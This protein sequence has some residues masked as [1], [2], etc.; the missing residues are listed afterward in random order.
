MGEVYRARDTRLDRQVAVKVLASHLSSNPEVRTRFDREARAISKL[1]HPHICAL[2]DV[3][4]QDGIDYLV[5]EYLE[6]E[7]LADRLAKGP[8]PLNQVIRLGSEIAEALDKAHRQGIVHRDLKPGNI[9]ITDAGAKV[10][11]FGLAKYTA[12]DAA[13]GTEASALDTERKPVT[14]EGTIL[15]TIQ[16]MAPEQLEGKEAD[17]RTDI[18]ALGTILYEMATGQRAFQGHSKASLIASIMSSEPTPIGAIQPMTPPPLDR[19]VRTCLEKDPAQR[20]QSAHDIACQL[21][22]VAEAPGEPLEAISQRRSRAIIT[23]G[24]FGIAVV[25]A[26]GLAFL[27]GKTR[28]ISVPM[29]QAAILP[30]QNSTFHFDIGPLALSPDGSQLAFVATGAEGRDFVWVRPIKDVSAH[31]LS[32]TEGASFPFWSPDGRSIGFFAEGKLKTIDASGGPALT[33]CEAPESRG[34]TWGRK[35]VIL[36]AP[37]P[38][39]PIHRISSSGGKAV[40]V[41]KIDVSE[42]ELGHRWPVFLPDGKHFLYLSWTG[43]W[44]LHEEQA[45]YVGAVDSSK[46]KLL[47]RAA[48]NAAYAP[49]GYILFLRGTDLM[50]QSFNLKRQ[51]LSGEA[52]LIAEQVQYFSDRGLVV[53][54]VSGNGLLAYQAGSSTAKTQLVWLDR[55]G[56]QI[57]VLTSQGSYFSP[58]ISHDGQRV[59]VESRDAQQNPDVWIH[60]LSRR[61]GAR[62]TFNPGLESSPVWSPDDRRIVFA[63]SRTT[64]ADLYEKNVTG[65]NERVVFS[66]DSRKEPTDWSPDGRFIV[67]QHQAKEGSEKIDLWIYSFGERKA[68]PLFAS[69]FNE[70]DGRF[71]PDGRW[72]AYVSDESKR[73]EVYVQ[74]FPSSG[75]KWQISAT[76]GFQPRWSGDGKE[77]F[78]LSLERKMMSVE[79]QTSPS[80]QAGN[81]QPLF[82]VR[83]PNISFGQYDV[84]SDG[85]RFLMNLP[86]A[87]QQTTP[88]TLVT[89]WSAKAVK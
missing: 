12:P 39:D 70:V 7:S 27:A 63:S 74:A 4:Q 75:S 62:F 17:A 49:P 89:N 45:I 30:P 47:L 10:L 61:V 31:A 55:S 73:Y 76:G 46:R 25:A 80:F 5:M 8:L 34:G 29:I 79:V 13:L 28:R 86:A 77:L 18:F 69:Q 50:A 1:S 48:S 23:W 11:D 24:S 6:G 67:F 56:K 68:V 54:S 38:R 81:P 2:H 60:D 65:G 14:A 36:F 53:F 64:T 59:A 21:R 22:W 71:S 88:I 85:E 52:S 82:E 87:D 16:Y 19:V 20:W 3:G 41:T 57:D 66:A 72:M 84:S 32:G 35:G 42:R 51:E 33:L 43:F 40:A 58:R 15:G 9:M 78:Y 37:T 26:L 44:R 83:I